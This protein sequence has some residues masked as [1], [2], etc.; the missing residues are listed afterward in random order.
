MGRGFR[1]LQMILIDDI[2]LGTPQGV[3][4]NSGER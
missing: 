2:P 3:Y 4:I 1:L